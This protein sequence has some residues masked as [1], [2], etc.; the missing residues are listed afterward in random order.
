[1]VLRTIA[2]ISAFLLC[3]LTQLASAQ[4]DS[5]QNEK[6][7][8][9]ALHSSA[10]DKR[11]IAEK[12]LT[13]QNVKQDFEVAYALLVQASTAGDITAMRDMGYLLMHGIGIEQNTTDAFC[14]FKQAAEMGD[15]AS[16]V[17]LAYCYANG[18]GTGSNPQQAFEHYTK[19]AEIGD[20]D[21]MYGLARCYYMGFGTEQN[22]GKAF[23]YASKAAA[24]GQAEACYCVGHSYRSGEGVDIDQRVAIQYFE[25]SLRL[26]YP[27]PSDVYLEM[28]L[29]YESLGE[30]KQMVECYQQGSNLGDAKCKY[31]LAICFGGGTGVEKDTDKAM[32]L[33]QECADQTADLE[34]Q[35]AAKEL[36]E[37]VAANNQ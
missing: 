5:L 7:I 1:M 4:I 23:E 16:I 10:S 18:V 21:A 15:T 24:E 26:G 12:F 29:S 13:G 25:Q 22:I 30:W 33:L 9:K 36:I 2:S 3:A 34:I 37:S 11:E 20:S 8:Q 17:A 32:V 31:C 28:A 27:N 14:H 6:M 19:A 35:A